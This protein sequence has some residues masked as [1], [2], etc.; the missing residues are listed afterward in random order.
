MQRIE[1]DLTRVTCLRRQIHV[2]SYQYL[3]EYSRDTLT[4]PHRHISALIIHTRA[5]AY[6]KCLILRLSIFLCKEPITEPSSVVSRRCLTLK[7]YKLL[8]RLLD[9]SYYGFSNLIFLCF[10][11]WLIWNTD[12]E[13]SCKLQF[14]Y[15]KTHKV[16]LNVIGIAVSKL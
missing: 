7:I 11:F 14:C 4:R 16:A 10:M 2:T 13:I 8:L 15:F 3:I 1:G 12:I 5:R 6:S 9:R